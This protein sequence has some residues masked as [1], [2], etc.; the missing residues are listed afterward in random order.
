MK[1]L[2]A[3]FL[4]LIFVS[5]LFAQSAATSVP[6]PN[7]YI[8]QTATFKAIVTA[9]QSAITLPAG[10]T[11]VV[12]WT[13]NDPLVTLTPSVVLGPN[14]EPI[15]TIVVMLVPGN[16]APKTITLTAT[17]TMPDGSK[18]VT[19]FSVPALPE[20]ITYAISVIQT[21]YTQ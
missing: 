4:P 13:S 10:Y 5:S 11:F 15:G 21:A 18:A 17:G 7:V 6:M 16:D 20:P 19:N 12:V 2:T 9:N 3:L 14:G 1:K 8:G